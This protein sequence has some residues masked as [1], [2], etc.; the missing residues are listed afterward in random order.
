MHKRW[1]NKQDLDPVFDQFRDIGHGCSLNQGVV[2]FFRQQD[3]NLDAGQNSAAKSLNEGPVGDKV[4]GHN[5]NV[6]PG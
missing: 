4:G 2:T 5:E 1:R 6:I 3:L